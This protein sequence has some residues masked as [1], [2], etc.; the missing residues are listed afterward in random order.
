MF[1][2]IRNSFVNFRIGRIGTELEIGVNQRIGYMSKLYLIWNALQ[3]TG[4][5]Y[6]L[7]D[8]FISLVTL[9]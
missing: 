7:K 8:V 6:K 9:L 4:K 3:V 5:T 2:N 1:R